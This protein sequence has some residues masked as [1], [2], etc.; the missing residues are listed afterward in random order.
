MVAGKQSFRTQI[1]EGKVHHCASRLLGQAHSPILTA[2]VV[3]QF[4]NLLLR[5]VRA[6]SGASN[7]FVVGQQEDGP[8]LN[9]MGTQRRDFFS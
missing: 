4:V 3:S 9:V 7:V 1:L 6:Q 2:E 8:I 5:L